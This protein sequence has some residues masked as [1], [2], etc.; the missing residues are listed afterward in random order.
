MK[1]VKLLFA[2]LMIAASALQSLALE[3]FTFP[4]R[5]ADV[6]SGTYW[7][8]SE[9]NEGFVLDL[10]LQKYGSTQWNWGT[11]STTNEQDF[12]FSMPL[13]APANGRV[14]SCWRNFPDDP[15]PE[16]QPPGESQIFGGGNHVV[17]L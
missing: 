12:D 1:T 6:D 8:V 16:V 2:I 10:N 14:I 15:A 3:T 17:I 7:V 11:G 5:S 13:Y 4:A 9:F